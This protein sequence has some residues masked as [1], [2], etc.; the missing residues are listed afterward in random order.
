MFT[1][2]TYIVFY[3]WAPWYGL[4]EYTITTMKNTLNYDKT[5]NSSSQNVE[6][7]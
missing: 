6:L 3:R 7:W 1:F 5:T 4:R 2:Y